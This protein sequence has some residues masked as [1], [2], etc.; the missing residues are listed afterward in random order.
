[1]SAT[2]PHDDPAQTTCDRR[3]FFR[4]SDYIGLEIRKL[5]ADN[6]DK[7]NPFNG[8]HLE[9]LRSELKRLDQDVKA[10]LTTLAERDRLLTSLIKS[11]NGKL[12]TLARIMAFEQNPLQPEDWQDVTLSEGGLAFHT[13][14]NSFMIDEILALRMT[15]PPE[16]FQPVAIAKV[17]SVEPDGS[18]GVRVHT[19]F[20]DIHDSD[21]QQIARHVMRWQ[22]RQ[23]QN[24]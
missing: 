11:L 24:Q 13:A 12:D 18:Q 9:S 2:T 7:E 4:I 1:M 5:D 23:R 8:S 10:Q 3:D 15:L 17:V 14:T 16:L 22:I 21:R 19:E 20:T 6:A